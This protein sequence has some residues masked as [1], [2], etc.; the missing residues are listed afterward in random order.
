MNINVTEIIQS[1]INELQNEG[2]VEKAIT[3]TFKTAL[4]K[5]VTDS[6]DS[7]N[8]RRIITDKMTKQVS[9]VLEQ[10][11]FQSYNGF[12]IEKMSQIINE[13]CREDICQKA[14]K[15]FK[16]LFL[17]QTKEIKLS[18]I[19]E[20]YR[21]IACE[22]VDESDKYNRIDE[23]W[24]CKCELSP[25]GWIDC[26]LDYEEGSHNY[27]SDSKI[28]FTVHRDYD[29][30]TKGKILTLYLDGYS[31]KEKFKFGCLNDVELMLVQAIINEIPIVI[32]VE[33]T[34]DIDN[35]FDVDY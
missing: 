17:C 20:K 21:E 18:S 29:N 8:I 13:I 2:A 33:S 4:I 12:M 1:K 27:R 30:K 16:D 11:D 3:E 14:E 15:K 32:D 26:E 34:D 31:V 23:G 6:L 5:A 7:H 19:F 28:A 22:N 35:S 10:L 25:H 9:K 24:H